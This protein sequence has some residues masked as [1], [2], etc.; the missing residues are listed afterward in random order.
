MKAYLATTG[1]LFGLISLAHVART[2]SE[3]SRFRTD[4]WFA[5]EGPGLG[6]VT[7]ALC[8]WAARLLFR[9]GLSGRGPA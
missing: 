3:W 6:L 2:I 1:S 4:P 8:L 5:L 9:R 7:G